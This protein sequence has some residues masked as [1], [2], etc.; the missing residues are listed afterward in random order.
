M[1]SSCSCATPCQHLD[2]SRKPGRHSL[3]RVWAECWAPN[4]GSALNDTPAQSERPTGRPICS[5]IRLWNLSFALCLSVCVCV[6]GTKKLRT[7][8]KIPL[9][10]QSVNGFPW[11]LALPAATVAYLKHRWWNDFPSHECQIGGRSCAT[12]EGFVR[13]HARVFVPAKHKRAKSGCKLTIDD[14]QNEIDR[15][16]RLSGKRAVSGMARRARESILLARYNI[17]LDMS[18]FCSPFLLAMASL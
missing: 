5:P 13:F 1:A 14:R 3:R 9:Y 12:V 10:P 18:I 15:S 17:F 6:W 4:L 8:K 2:W 7:A 16:F 11:A